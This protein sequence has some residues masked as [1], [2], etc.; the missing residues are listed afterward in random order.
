LMGLTGGIEPNDGSNV[1]RSSGNLHMWNPSQPRPAT[2]WEAEI[3]KLMDEGASE[4]DTP[5]RAPYYWR[6][7]QIL[8]DQLAFIQTVRRTDYV[9]WTDSLENFQLKIWGQY[10]PE[11]MEFKVN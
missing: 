1:Y 4:M 9:T 7:Q 2:A 5:K 10:K 8:H 6:I 3:D 11:W